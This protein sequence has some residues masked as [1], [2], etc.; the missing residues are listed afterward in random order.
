MTRRP[1]TTEISEQ[2][3]SRFLSVKA[4][5]HTICSLFVTGFYVFI[6]AVEMMTSPADRA[7]PRAAGLR[8]TSQ[9]S[10]R[11]ASTFSS[12]RKRVELQGI[13]YPI[14]VFSCLL[15][16]LRFEEET[17]PVERLLAFSS[18]GS[19]RV[20]FSKIMTS[21]VHFDATSYLMFISFSTFLPQPAVEGVLFL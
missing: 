2:T 1:L 4:T 8:V 5:D 20:C 19:Q 16:E 17:L 7:D 9:T 15:M 3:P 18:A 12:L 6:V 14:S 13:R 10:R 11:F 21:S